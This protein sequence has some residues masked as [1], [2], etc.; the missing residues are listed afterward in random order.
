MRIDKELAITIATAAITEHY[1]QVHVLTTRD[2][3]RWL[4]DRDISFQWE[5]L[6][7][8]WELGV[9]HPI[10]ILEPAICEKTGR[11]RFLG[12]DLGYEKRSFVDWG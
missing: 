5:T 7:H 8:L 10:A 2:F 9:L 6:H 4:K 12:V 3:V 11:Y 1:R